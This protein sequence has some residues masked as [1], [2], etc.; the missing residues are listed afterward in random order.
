MIMPFR[1]LG[2]EVLQPINT[3]AVIILGVFT[4]LWGLWVFSPF[5]DVFNRAVVY[6]YF[7]ILPEYFWGS[8]AIASGTAMIYGV[9]RNSYRSLTMGSMVGFL[10]WFVIMA[11]FFAGDWQNTGG[12]TYLMIAVYCGYIWLNL[13]V[14]KKNFA[15]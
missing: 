2:R 8:V 12:V 6:H 5:W 4:V 9:L 10:H 1:R 14:N 7:Q 11:F 3:A 15:S 13:R